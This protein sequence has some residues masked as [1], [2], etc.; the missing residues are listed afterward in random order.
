[1]AKISHLSLAGPLDGSEDVPVLQAGVTKRINPADH[2][3]YIA[4]GAELARDQAADLVSGANIFID[5]ALPVAEADV[6]PGAFFKI[7]DTATGIAD[8]RKRTVGGSDHLYGEA[9]T[10]ALA[11]PTGAEKSGFRTRTVFDNLDDKINL[12]DRGV[13]VDNAT[14]ASTIMNDVAD[15]ARATGKGIYLPRCPGLLYCAEEV[16][17]TGIRTIAIETPIRFDDEIV[18]IP[19]LLGGFAEGDLCDWWFEDV[20]DGTPVAV[21]PPPARPI[22]RITGLKGST[23]RFGSCNYLQLY[24]D[25]PAGAAWSSTAYNRIYLDG[26]VSQL[27]L[28]DAGGFS[29]VNENQIY[30]SRVDRLKI[31]GVGY[32]HNHNRI[33]G[34]TFEG[35]Q[36][37]AEFGYCSH[38]RV[39]GARGE[40]IGASNGISFDDRSY[41]NFISFSWSGSGTP[42][43]D[44]VVACDVADAGSG[45]M[46]T[47]EAAVM[48]QKVRV[49]DVG[50]HSGIVASAAASTAANPAVSPQ[51]NPG[52]DNLTD[53]PIL[54]PSLDGFSVGGNRYI[55]LTPPI[56]VQRG[57]VLVWQGDY[58]GALL[59][60]STF[61]LDANQRPLTDEG[62]G[63]E[64]IDQPGTEFV[65]AYGRY[66][67]GGDL[68]S[69]TLRQ[70]PIAIMRDEVKF[71]RLGAFSATG[72]FFKSLS[73][74]LFVNP[75][76]RAPAGAISGAH[77]QRSLPGAPVAG[78][79][80]L[81]TTIF[82]RTAK[83]TRFVTLEHESRITAARG[84]TDTVITV[85]DPSTIANG[86]L[87]GILLDNGATHW[88]VVAALAGA[89][90]SVAALPSAAGAGAR[91]V[92]NRW[93]S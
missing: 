26:L 4:Q 49:A 76:G 51:V 41:S 21:T 66:L 30:A 55:V 64:F 33:F 84:A 56:P 6:A 15:E 65:G 25:L 16:D 73:L 3:A 60:T 43:N 82:D 48:R 13:V 12:L 31:N 91:I 69:E 17:L 77:S 57:D 28:T 92:F 71:V 44:F 79:L 61:V 42:R 35:P 18:E 58:Q 63:G 59:R 10:A 36:F 72:G 27:E 34:A 47:T 80:P 40:D 38:N 2:L 5:V 32:P 39:I 53:I 45:N 8:V 87:V 93:A 88:S 50:P 19:M 52:I 68:D 54:T 90:F 23:V 89:V 86:D 67:Q 46:V 78:F 29:W 11:A 9:T 75:L 14:S 81:G 24:A 85:A 70:S 37:L 22:V 1:M 62:A 83:V 7:I 74:S 20:T